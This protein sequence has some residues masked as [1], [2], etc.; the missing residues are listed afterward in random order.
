MT[1]EEGMRNVSICLFLGLSVIV[2]AALGQTAPLQEVRT[3]PTFTGS[4]VTDGNQYSYTMAGHKPESGGTTTIPTV[5]VPLSLSF[6]AGGGESGRNGI[7]MNAE[8]D[9]PEILHSPVFQSF[10]FATG[11][12]QYGDA[13]QRAQF[14]KTAAKAS[15]HTLLE[16]QPHVAATIHIEVPAANGYALHSRRTGK[17][18]G[19]VDLDFVQKQLFQNLA[20]TGAWSDKLL[21]ALTANVVFYSL[22]DATVCCSVGTHGAQLD[23]S[24]TSAQ[25]FVIGSYFDKSVSAAL[26]GYPRHKPAGCRVDERSTAWVSPE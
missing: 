8:A 15:W 12:T 26:H 6:T 3:V 22:S 19:V 23:S 2:Q 24:G 21:I 5:I 4:F 17:S 14:Y 1:I 13:V 25:A 20:S 9:V 18:L 16:H 7:V 10:A 11:K